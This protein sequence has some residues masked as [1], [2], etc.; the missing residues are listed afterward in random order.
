MF[1]EK[2]WEEKPELVLKAIKKIAS[3]DEELVKDLSFKGV[4]EKGALIFGVGNIYGF[5]TIYVKDFSFQGNASRDWGGLVQTRMIGEN[6]EW[7]KFMYKVFGEE[8]IEKYITLRN[9]ELDKEMYQ[10]EKKHTNA[11]INVLAKIGIKKYQDMQ[12]QIK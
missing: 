2:L 7:M 5:C 9:H 10:L 6:V 1:V 3:V 8:Y 4:D 11:T 12:N